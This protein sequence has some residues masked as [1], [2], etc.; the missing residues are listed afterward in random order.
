M[1]RLC[2]VSIRRAGESLCI[3][4]WF[5]VKSTAVRSEFAIQQPQR[6]A[7]HVGLA[8]LSE[9][10][11][12]PKYLSF[13]YTKCFTSRKGSGGSPSSRALPEQFGRETERAQNHLG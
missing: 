11:Q 13:M 12:L 9:L 1:G 4:L 2:S 3:Y 10:G 8:H 5:R 7:A 6:F